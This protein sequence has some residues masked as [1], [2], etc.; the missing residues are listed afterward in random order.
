MLSKAFSFA[1]IRR[2]FWIPS[3]L[4]YKELRSDMIPINLYC[5]KIINIFLIYNCPDQTDMVSKAL[6]FAL[7]RR[8]F[9]SR[10]TS[11][12][13]CS[14]KWHIRKDR[15]ERTPSFAHL[16]DISVRTANIVHFFHQDK[17]E[18]FLL[19]LKKTNFPI[20]SAKLHLQ[21]EFS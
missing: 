20:L 18:L 16:K 1:H 8:D 17:G 9:K 6:N 14:F 15:V 7:V 2:D 11:A 13:I 19:A 3:E 12:I 10:R 4:Y 5:H 21:L